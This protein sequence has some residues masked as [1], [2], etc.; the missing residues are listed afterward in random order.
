MF[1]H[2]GDDSFLRKDLRNIRIEQREQVG[3]WM[4]VSFMK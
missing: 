1:G 3:S 4:G 2:R